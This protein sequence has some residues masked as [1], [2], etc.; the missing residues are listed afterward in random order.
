MNVVEEFACLPPWCGLAAIHS[1]Q[2]DETGLIKS[3][4]THRT[5]AGS[6]DARFTIQHTHQQPR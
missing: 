1:I 6:N 3:R 5:A 4:R 2:I